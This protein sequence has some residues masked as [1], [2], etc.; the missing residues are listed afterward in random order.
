M[1]HKSSG[2]S[3]NKDDILDFFK[4]T[5]RILSDASSALQGNFYSQNFA[6]E[7]EFWKWLDRN[8]TNIDFSSKETIIDYLSKKGN[9]TQFFGKIYEYDYANHLREKFSNLF[10]DFDLPDVLNNEGFDLEESSLFEGVKRYQLKSYASGSLNINSNK[11]PSTYK[12]ITNIEN[13]DEIRQ[14]GFE[15]EAFMDN[16]SIKQ[17][18]SEVLNNALEG[19][20]NI[21]YDFAG[22]METIG[23]GFQY[24]FVIGV[25]IEAIASFKKFKNG[26]INLKKYLKEI[27]KSGAEKGLT[28]GLTTGVMVPIHAV[29][30]SN[31]ITSIISIPIAF[32]VHQ[33][34]AKPISA[35]FGKGEYKEILNN[36]KIYNSSIQMMSDFGVMVKETNK[37]F[38]KFIADSEKSNQQFI[39]RREEFKEALIDFKN[40]TGG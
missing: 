14:Q 3:F 18:R 12:I 4:T 21:D 17:R 37:G 35:A 8:Y 6:E 26:D 19:N 1:S 20:I 11:I 27:M 10:S 39:K 38:K 15:V 33:T 40:K 30:Q 2:Q 13:V 36:A 5:S 29:L 23:K 9:Q 32:L 7:V 22:V 34:I 24:G 16:E 25:G 28:S 31:L